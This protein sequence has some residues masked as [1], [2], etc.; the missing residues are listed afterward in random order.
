MLDISELQL[1]FG[2]QQVLDNIDCSLEA[3]QLVAII[4]ENGAGKST[5]LR[6]LAGD[7]DYRGRIDLHGRELRQWQ[8][9]KLARIRAVMEQQQTL[10]FALTVAELVAI[11]RHPYA[12]TEA[13]QLAAIEPWLARFHLDKLAHREVTSLSGGERQRAQLARCMTQLDGK[14]EGEKLLLLDEPTSALDLYHQ[15]QC[16]R[17]VK[18][19]CQ[20]GNL[21]LVVLHDLNLASLYADQVLVI[22]QGRLFAHGSAQTVFNRRCLQSVYSTPMYISQHPFLGVPMV[23]SEPEHLHRQRFN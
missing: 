12:E 11:G 5:L 10:S 20:H 18:Q 17:A 13:Q 23:F 14:L 6:S 16:L 15:H 21:A 3:G 22:H 8:P 9:D 19:F 1:N 7:H 4:G 2:R